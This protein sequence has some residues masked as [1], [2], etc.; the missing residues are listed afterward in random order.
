[1]SKIY[2][3]I[4]NDVETG[5]FTLQELLQHPLTAS[6]LVW[7][8]GQSEDWLSPLKVPSLQPYF[9][10][11]AKKPVVKVAVLKAIRNNT[12]VPFV[13]T[14]N[15]RPP[16]G[17]LD[18]RLLDAQPEMQQE[19]IPYS[20]AQQVTPRHDI[21]KSFSTAFNN[22]QQACKKFTKAPQVAEG[23]E[24]EPVSSLP[25]M[26]VVAVLILFFGWS[27]FYNKTGKPNTNNVATYQPAPATEP[28]RQIA[29]T[30]I[31]TRPA[32]PVV[33]KTN[34]TG[35][36]A[37][38]QSSIDEYLDSV[39]KVIARQDARDAASHRFLTRVSNRRTLTQKFITP[40]NTKPVQHVQQP[41]AAVKNMPLYQQVAL[42]SH[43]TQAGN[44]KIEAVQVGVQN[45]SNAVL[46]KV[47]VDVFYY[48]K[49]DRL[50]DKETVYFNNVAPH[51]LQTLMLPGNRRASSAQFQLGM[52]IGANEK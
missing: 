20:S 27:A 15:Q 49:G 2:L 29:Y 44:K 40:I 31:S 17:F 41:I 47:S 21:K 16:T 8:I 51:Q 4:Q 10:A 38:T 43:Y 45:N 5:P 46:K 14:A 25:L 22:V 39:H 12:F 48:K 33:E 18:A 30:P 24:E 11:R 9:S 32:N 3:L 34:Y 37:N 23:E 19:K 28:A 13:A 50:F 35:A 7:Q 52:V 6:D 42:Q 26:G 36:T 1:M